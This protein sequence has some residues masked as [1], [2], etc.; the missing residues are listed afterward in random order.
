VNQRRI[1][2]D[3]IVSCHERLVIHAMSS[4][5]ARSREEKPS[6]E[7]ASAEEKLMPSTTTDVLQ[8]EPRFPSQGMA[9]IHTLFENRNLWA[10]KLSNQP[11]LIQRTQSSWHCQTALSAYRLTRSLRELV[12]NNSTTYAGAPEESFEILIPRIGHPCVAN[13]QLLGLLS[14]L[15]CRWNKSVKLGM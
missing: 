7:F 12:A 6:K 3:L 9:R 10:E 1:L 15:F 11:L 4:R 5:A 13:V 2:L 8:R 14:S